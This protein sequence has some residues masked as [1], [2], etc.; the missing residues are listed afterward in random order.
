MDTTPVAIITNQDFLDTYERL[1]VL[2][3]N[4]KNSSKTV[5]WEQLV[6]ILYNLPTELYVLPRPTDDTVSQF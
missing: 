3:K 4:V 2:K 1:G 5:D 6:E